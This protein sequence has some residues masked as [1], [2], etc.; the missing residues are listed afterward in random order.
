MDN[1]ISYII[2]EYEPNT[3]I[4]YGSFADG[5]NNANS[6]FDA[7]I[8]TD[9]ASRAH[10]SSVVDGVMLD[11]FIYHTSVFNSDVDCEKYLPIFDGKI[12]LDK[13]NIGA[14]LKK[15]VNEY[16]DSLP[17]KT[18][19][20]NRTAVEWCEKMLLRTARGDAEGYYRWHWVLT[21]SLEIYCD[22][23]KIPYFGPKKA[24]KQMQKNHPGD[25]EIYFTA[26]SALDRNAL[27]KWIKILRDK[28]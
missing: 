3:I 4:L 12:I 7:L 13:N 10:D 19:E 21:E 27:E 15:R 16:I 26:L 20:E 11:L 28:L 14:T 18:D 23:M 6:D 1:I 22:I 24:L 9:N 17:C 8:I 2:K 25:A 5:S